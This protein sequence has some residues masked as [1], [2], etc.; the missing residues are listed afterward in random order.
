MSLMVSLSLKTHLKIPI[1]QV[2]VYMT[3]N[4]QLFTSTIV[5]PNLDRYSRFFM[6]WLIYV[7][8]TSGFD[9]LDENYFVNQLKGKNKKIE[10]MCNEFAGSFWFRKNLFQKELN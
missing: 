9:P 7:F 2:F 6:S 10:V 3:K 4:F 1:F 5:S 8:H